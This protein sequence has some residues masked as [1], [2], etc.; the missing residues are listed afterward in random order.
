V[1]KHEKDIQRITPHVNDPCVWK[2]R[3]NER[4]E[5]RVERHLIGQPQC[6]GRDTVGFLNISAPERMQRTTHV[7][8]GLRGL[9][10]RH[11]RYAILEG[12]QFAAR[13][14]LGMG[15]KQRLDERCAR[16]GHPDDEDWA[17][18]GITAIA[19]RV[20]K[21]TAQRVIER[22]ERSQHR[23][24][25]VDDALATQPIRPLEH[26]ECFLK[27]FE[28]TQDLC[29]AKQRI[30]AEIVWHPLS[31]GRSTLE[32]RDDRVIC[33]DRLVIGKMT[34]KAPVVRLEFDRTQRPLLSFGQVAKFAQDHTEIVRGF[35]V[36]RIDV[37][38]RTKGINC[39]G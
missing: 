7:G 24:F 5:A 23:R 8:D 31:S 35:T 12:H 2:R 32:L 14:N 9:D 22:I 4:D 10:P 1:A 6:P 3:A 21:G 37:Q 26:R 30:N 36:C 39:S 13:A 20:S 25:V 27:A 17:F 15:R 28:V 29:L 34:K 19:G 18:R 33:P 11:P 16:P 38:S